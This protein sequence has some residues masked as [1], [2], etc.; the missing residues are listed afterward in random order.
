[1]CSELILV[2]VTI[3]FTNSP[4]NVIVTTATT[5]LVINILRSRAIR[6]GVQESDTVEYYDRHKHKMLWFMFKSNDCTNVFHIY[7]THLTND[8]F[9]VTESSFI[10]NCEIVAT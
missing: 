1:M 10:I 7:P 8:S 5:R 4:H 2:N 6:V 3:F 9:A